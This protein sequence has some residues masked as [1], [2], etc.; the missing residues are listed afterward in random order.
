[1]LIF[2]S[3]YFDLN[4]IEAQSYRVYQCSRAVYHARGYIPGGLGVGVF[5]GESGRSFFNS[6]GS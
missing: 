4:N 2:W 5:H 1:M 3:I 6:S